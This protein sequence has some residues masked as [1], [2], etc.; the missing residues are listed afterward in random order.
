MTS[1][2]YTP[3]PGSVAQRAIAHLESL[4]TGAELS[5]SA[6][7]EAAGVPLNG[8]VPCLQSAVEAGALERRQ[9]G[10]HVRSPI[11]WSLAR[12]AGD[13]PQDT[14][15]LGA[16]QVNC[17]VASDGSPQTSGA[18]D[19]PKRDHR[20]PLIRDR[21]N[22][23]TRTSGARSPENDVTAGETAPIRIALWSDGE[24]H[25][26]RDTGRGAAEVVLLSAG[27]TRALVRYLD[28][29]VVREEG[30]A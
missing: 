8:L 23:G 1:G 30:M 3:R 2:V 29:M 7:A 16:R 12:A 4:P 18:H 24:L 19:S 15:I 26:E 28:R 25:I 11:F 20:G 5:S 17:G 22:R 21:S 10:G 6:L 13:Q 27:E 9:R 14:G